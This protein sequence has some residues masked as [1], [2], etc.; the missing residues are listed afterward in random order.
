MDLV[1]TQDGSTSL[2]CACANGHTEVAK[3][4]LDSGVMW[5]VFVQWVCV[6]EADHNYMCFIVWSSIW[7][8][9]WSILG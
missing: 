2:H 8:V 6:V 4:L 5:S 3:F 7:V 9:W 1:S